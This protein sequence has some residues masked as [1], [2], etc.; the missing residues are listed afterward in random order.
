[1]PDVD[2]GVVLADDVTLPSVRCTGVLGGIVGP[3]LTALV[4]GPN[5]AFTLTIAPPAATG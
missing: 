2:T 1:V 4:S 5:N 3:P